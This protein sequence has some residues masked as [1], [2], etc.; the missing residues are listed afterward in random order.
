MVSSLA[1][2]YKAIPDP[3]PQSITLRW[4]A[5]QDKEDKAFFD[6][7]AVGDERNIKKLW[8]ACRDNGLTASYTAFREYIHN[9]YDAG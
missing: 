9:R 7:N 3:A 8:K 4:Y 5:A 6:Q 1:E 2:R